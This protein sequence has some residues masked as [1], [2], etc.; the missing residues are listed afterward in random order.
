MESQVC[1]SLTFS[2]MMTRLNSEMNLF[3]SINTSNEMFQV[4]ITKSTLKTIIF[5]MK[6]TTTLQSDIALLVA[7][8]SSEFV[9]E[10]PRFGGCV[11]VCVEEGAFT[12]A[13]F[14][15]ILFM[16]CELVKQLT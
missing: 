9:T 16:G 14:T 7:A 12:S 4:H 2:V 8:N 10:V 6:K 15:K 13:S 1:K 5:Q 3:S 11:C